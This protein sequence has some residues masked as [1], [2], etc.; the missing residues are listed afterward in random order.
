MD[1]GLSRR[2]LWKTAGLAAV[3][4][5]AAADRRA[6]RSAIVRRAEHYLGQRYLDVDYYRIRRQLAYPLPVESLSI[7]AVPVPTIAEYPWATWM[8]WALEER[9]HSLGWAA[10][11]TGRA[12]FAGAAARDLEAL[13]R[14]PKYCQYR[15]PDL[16]SGHAGRLMWA[17][18]S[19]WKWP[20]ASLRQSL[21]QA[22]R[23]HVE[24]VLPLAAAYYG[25]LRSKEDLLRLPEPE[26]KLP[27]IPLIGT[28]AAALTAR[29]AGHPGGV[30]LNRKVRAVMG[31]ILDLRTKGLTEAVAY[32][33][34]ILDFVADWLGMIP[35]GER[36][37]ILDHP[38]FRHYL[39]ES[40][41]LS[42]PGAAAEVAQLSDVEPR[43]MPFHHSAQA[44]L[45]ALQPDP[46]RA[47]HLGRW[48]QDWIRADA[49]GVLHSQAN[50][51]AGKAPEA[52]A[53]QAHY[54]VVLRSGWEKE[55]L[56]VVMS[57]TNSAMGHVQMDNG[58]LV[59]GA[60]GRWIISDPGY[61]QYMRDAEREFTVGP[62]AHNYPLLDGRAQNRKAP[63]LL[64]LETAG[65]GLWRAAVELAGCYPEEAQARSVRRDVWLEGRRTVVV[66]DRIAGGP[67]QKVTYH[68][69]GHPEA[70]W[71]AKEGWILLHTPEADL[72]LTSPQAAVGHANIQRLAGSR[73]Q[74][75]LVAEADPKA[76]VIWWVFAVG[77][78]APELKPGTDGRSIEISGVRFQ[79]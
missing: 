10:E 57:C 46:V 14:W 73:G 37:E 60:R 33:G 41:M 25:D 66:A 70:A 16:S 24:E 11:W 22:C 13:C 48:R 61:Q 77:Q 29:V 18:S 62:A 79:V 40:Y 3:S 31:A 23:R 76:P 67:F 26:R 7:P 74:L 69:H 68:W 71:W 45:A 36:S 6:M 50:R 54:A 47:W 21:R 2:D 20:S 65:A 27:N 1:Q 12:E 39:E 53:L 32:D 19:R 52:G 28:V 56:A 75:T 58:T 49:L 42:A 64:Q 8:L 15:Q 55:D 51:A 30:E 43:E 59:L 44:K 38:N 34:Y 5:G 17:A 9:V 4:G 63:R 72:W 35:P 78:A